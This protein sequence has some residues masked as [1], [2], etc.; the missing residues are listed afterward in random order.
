MTC[1]R[2]AT[3]SPASCWRPRPWTAARGRGRVGVNVGRRA[4]GHALSGDSL[5]RLG[6]HAGPENCSWRCGPP[7]PSSAASGM[8]AAASARSA[9]CGSTR[10]R[11]RRAGRDRVGQ[12]RHRGHLRHPRRDRLHDRGPPR[13]A[14]PAGRRR[15]CAF[16]IGPLVGSRLMTRPD[17][18]N[19]APLGG[20]GE[21]GM[22]LSV[23]GLAAATSAA[24]SPSISGLVRQRGAPAGHRRHHAGHQ[25]PAKERKNLVG[26]VLTHA[27]ED[28]FGATSTCGL[29]CDAR[30]MR[31]GS[32]RRCSRPSA[33]ASAIRRRS[34]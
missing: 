3:S 17:E 24:S 10:C 20:V 34:R 11:A 8:A 31:R 18:L 5:A 1:W 21:I 33:P 23:Y 4:R 6:I 26:L 22:N 32:A 14:P 25:L 30:S 9:G 16:R 15:R 2:A 7:G 28:H 13:R 29:S 27:H 12:R 19:F